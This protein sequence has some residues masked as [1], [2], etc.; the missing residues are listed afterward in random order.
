M[1]HFLFTRLTGAA[2]TTL[3]LFSAHSFGDELSKQRSLFLSVEQ[4]LK[5]GNYQPYRKHRKQ[6]ESYPLSPYLE[7]LS[8]SGN[9]KLLDHRVV[10]RFLNRYPNLPQA[11]QLQRQWLRH[12]AQN[13]QWKAY[14][15]AYQKDDGGR[16]QCMK[17]RA[18]YELGHKDSAWKEAE[19]LWL[20]GDSQHKNC[21]TLFKQWKAAGQLT[22]PL[23]LSRFWLAVEENNLSLARYLDSKLHDKQLKAHTA[24]FWKIKRKPTL[25]ANTTFKDEFP[26]L[27]TTLLYGIQKMIST[28]YTLAIKTWLT[29]RK[30]YPFTL[31][32][33]AKVDQRIALKAAKNFRDDA[34]SIIDKIDPDFQYHEVTQ[35]RVRNALAEQ[36]WPSVIR[37]IEKLPPAI[38]HES[39]WRYWIEVAQLQFLEETNSNHNNVSAI[40]NLAKLRTPALNLLSK[41]RN[42]YA[43][44]VAERKGKP[45][46][47]NHQ[48]QVVQY[49]DIETLSQIHP[50]VN[51]IKEWAHHQRFYAAQSE[52]NRLT[53]VLTQKQAAL[54]PYLAK[55]WQWYYQAIMTA[56]K[57]ELWNDI[58]LR[59]P[60]PKSSLFT[61]HA[62]KNNLD[63]PWVIAIAR[64]ESAFHPRARSH[65]GAMGLMQLMPATA[66]QAAQQAGIVLK[67]NTELYDPEI[68]IALGTTH[69]SWLSKRFDNSRV[70]ATAAYNA[71]ST[72]VNRWLKQRGHLPLD[73][74]I[75]TIPYDET[76]KY[77]QNVMAFRIIYSQIDNQPVR[78]FSLEEMAAI[79]L[80]L[81][82]SPLIAQQSQQKP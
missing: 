82:A 27:R 26:H 73:I 3:L 39:R 10:S 40:S 43:F 13:K 63:Y 58:D 60:T 16:Y 68:N 30:Q 64:Q 61:H 29:L 17:G 19:A 81:D 48:T 70:L 42:F 65:A 11:T 76:R 41:E 62:N 46:R 80:N 38:R 36:D 18:L 45:F 56:A 59:F 15:E 79:S 55:E 69:L 77:V 21:N 75:E 53:P 57:A 7:Y 50:G 66:K 25:L 28:H 20:T 72:A 44:L 35:W 23:I 67:K 54:I 31:E 37:F 32:E 8:L 34:N 51:R 2:L 78:M 1:L 9:L 12:L 24:R 4:A 49:Q 47:L 52:M 5:K 14:L 33:K 74:W 6:L 71:G 22:Q